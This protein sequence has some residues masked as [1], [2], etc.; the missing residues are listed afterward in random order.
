MTKSEILTELEDNIGKM[1]ELIA[2]QKFSVADA[3]KFLQR[4]FNIA[5]KMEQ[6]TI[7]RDNWKAKYIKL[8][9]EEVKK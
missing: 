7:S 5:R 8:K 1:E 9:S 3:Q 6:L 4:Y 2:N